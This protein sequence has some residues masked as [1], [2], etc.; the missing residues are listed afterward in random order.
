MLAFLA[1]RSYLRQASKDRWSALALPFIVMGSVMF[2]MLPAMEFA[3]LVAATIGADVEAAQAALDPWFI[4]TLLISGVLFVVGAIGF[5][6]GI[7]RS[8]VLSPGTAWIVAA[9]LFVM[10]ITRIIPLAASL[11][12]IGPVAGIVALWPLAYKMWNRR[13]AQPESAGAQPAV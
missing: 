11:M 9:A 13:Q 6:I 5:A 3:P 4:P 10:A 2:A 8:G 12:Y 7:V 1:L